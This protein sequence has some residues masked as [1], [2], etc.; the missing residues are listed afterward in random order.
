MVFDEHTRD[1]DYSDK[2]FTGNE[3]PLL[4]TFSLDLDVI[5]YISICHMFVLDSEFTYYNE[6]KC[7]QIGSGNTIYHLDSLQCQNRGIISRIF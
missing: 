7:D 3:E 1:V 2:S 6:L 4:I 5:D